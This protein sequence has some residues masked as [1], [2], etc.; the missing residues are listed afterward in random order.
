MAGRELTITPTKRERR[1]SP[2]MASCS[3]SSG[4]SQQPPPPPPPMSPTSSVADTTF[5][6]TVDMMVND[7]DDEATLN[8]EEALADLEAHNVEDEIA[9]LRAESE[10]PIEL[11]LAK[12]GSMEGDSVMRPCSSNSSGGGS[13]STSTKRRRR[14]KR[15]LEEDEQE[16][17]AQ[18]SQAEPASPLEY[19]EQAM[20]LDELPPE[21][22]KRSH[23]SHLLDLYPEEQA[24]KE[25]ESCRLRYENIKHSFYSTNSKVL[26]VIFS[27]SVGDVARTS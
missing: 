26:H 13:G 20:E 24:L 17:P 15:P 19:Q 16:Q 23:R 11:L 5:E 14:A 8:E 6:P 18:T 27:Y 3:T 21:V 10:M 1:K 4:T 7:F 9:T 2:A 25:L 22:T 12:Y